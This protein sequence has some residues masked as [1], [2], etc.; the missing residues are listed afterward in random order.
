MRE[1]VKK[2]L[3][4]MAEAGLLGREAAEAADA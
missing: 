2:D 3:A 1:A 4:C